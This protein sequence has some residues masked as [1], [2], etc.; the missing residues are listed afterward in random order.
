L[1]RVKVLLARAGAL[2]DLV[3]LRRVI[4][5]AR[6]AGHDVALLAPAAPAKVLVGIGSAEVAEVLDWNAPAFAGLFTDAGPGE[7]AAARLRSFDAAMA[8]T[9]T[10]ALATGLRALIPRVATHDPAPPLGGPHVS[11]WLASAL[12]AIGVRADVVVDLPILDPGPDERRAAERFAADLPP[13]FVALHPGSG[14]PAKNWPVDRFA[15]V[16]RSLAPARWLLVQ[17]PADEAAAA[18]LA[19]IPGAVIA[20]DLPLRTLA[21]LLSGAGAYVGN[22]SGVTHLTAAAGAPVVALFGAT[23]PRQWAPIGP[24]VRIVLCG[25]AMDAASVDTVIAAVED[26]RRRV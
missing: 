3:L 24:R 14:S 8:F 1:R 4:A 18:V 9:R 19:G 25:G 23:D 26:W 2:G 13:G 6:H 12:P 21:A 5:T 17:G 22:D 16:A 11:E 20:R 15:A 7:E 10:A